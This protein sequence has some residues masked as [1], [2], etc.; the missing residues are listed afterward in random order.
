MKNILLA[1]LVLFSAVG[2]GQDP[3]TGSKITIRS[4]TPTADQI[5]PGTTNTGFRK[6]D[7]AKL[8]GVIDST[9]VNLKLA[10]KQQT[11]VPA[12]NSEI[13]N[14]S[15]IAFWG[16]SFLFGAGG[17]DVNIVSRFIELSGMQAFNG[18]IGGQRS[19]Q[20]LARVTAATD[21]TGWS[22]VIWVGKNDFIQGVSPAT[23]KAN[24]ASIVSALGHNRYII[25]G[26]TP[27]T[28]D[29]TG[30]G[31][32]AA[33]T[34]I[35]TDLAAI[36]G[37][38]FFDAA[39]YLKTQGNGGSDNTAIS[40]GLL[41]PSLMNDAIHLNAAGYLLIANYLYA[42]KLNILQSASTN[43]VQV[44]NSSSL[45][46]GS[47]D[48]VYLKRG[49]K[50]F[51]GG[52]PAI[53]S[54]NQ[55]TNSLSLFV[56]NSSSPELLQSGATGNTGVGHNSFFNLTTGDDN[57]AIGK[58]ALYYLT[59]AISNTAVGS[60]ALFNNTANYNTAIGSDALTS[61]TTGNSN[62]AVGQNALLS[63]TTTS[64]NTAVGQAA[65]GLGSGGTGSSGFGY[66]ALLSSTGSNNTGIGNNAGDN[67][68]SGA[69][70]V[71]IGA[72]ADAQSATA[73]NQ[74]NIANV[75]WATGASGTGTTPAGNAGV[76]TNA[77]N[78]TF[79]ISGSF[80]GGYTAKTAT[81]TATISDYVINCT[82]NSFTVTVP[83]AVGIAGRIYIIKNTGAG[84]ITMATTSSQT[85]DGT[86]PPTIA[87]GAVLQIMSDGANWIKLN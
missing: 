17:G 8:A 44:A 76:G 61:N 14:N 27:S 86:T 7:S 18:G 84:T 28:S 33:I 66:H 60:A 55:T 63:N 83:S 42:N 23:I 50:V 75:F 72:D 13:I 9:L 68:T 35:N 48:Q 41:P 12:S 32:A 22:A 10:T 64:N 49:G 54:P 29:P 6:V 71:I 70:N 31:N 34:T 51:I 58:A 81:Y 57:T 59:T 11:I 36:Y 80:A 16:D 87:A 1:F 78:S 39:T 79:H 56:G 3:P 25:I 43:V 4:S 85:V 24:I 38:R 26:V 53:Y 30:S 20:V 65:L 40:N 19:D 2:Y 77:P 82:A 69:K 47:L 45:N 21:K 74:V 5:L 52:W 67:I 73:S 15:H 62:V 37:V 46:I